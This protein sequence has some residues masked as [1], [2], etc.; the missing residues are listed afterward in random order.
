LAGEKQQEKIISLLVKELMKL[1]TKSQI[2]RNKRRRWLSENL[3]A[4]SW[5][6]DL[7]ADGMP[8]YLF[9]LREQDLWRLFFNSFEW[10]ITPSTNFYGPRLINYRL[11]RGGESNK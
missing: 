7:K 11:G 1:L 9:S 6:Q 5:Q 4:G 8:R 2:E 10:P 3:K